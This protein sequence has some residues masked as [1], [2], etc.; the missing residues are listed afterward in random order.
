MSTFS[1]ILPAAGQSRRFKDAHY[2]KPYAT[3]S[4][5]AVWLHSA[6]KFLG[7]DDVVQLIVVVAPEDREEFDMK[8]S[9]N[10]AVLGIDVVE[11]GAERSDSIAAALACVRP[12]VDYIAVHDAARPCIVDAWITD[13]FEEVEKTGASIP[14]IPVAATLKRVRDDCVIDETVP[15]EHLWQAQTPQVFARQ[16]L[17]DAYAAHGDIRATDDA[18]L[19]ERLGHA[20]SVVPGSALNIKITTKEDLDLAAQILKVLPKP[21][22]PGPAHP[23]A[24]FP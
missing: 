4:G 10:V 17:I 22:L 24:D 20:V 1:V 2:K 19:V 13:L 23:F 21:R 6:E 9:A 15:R 14:A 16:L 3:L 5:R 7:R 18:Q 11:G 8:F 12:E